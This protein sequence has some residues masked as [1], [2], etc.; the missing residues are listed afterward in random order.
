MKRTLVYVSFL[1]LLLSTACQKK[2]Q[3][4]NIVFIIAE[5]I[6][7]DLGCY[8]RTD[9]KTPVLDTMAAEGML[10]MNAFTTS[11]VCSPSRSALMTGMYQNSIGTHNHR[12]ETGPLPDPFVPITYLLRDEG[13]FTC[14]VVGEEYGTGKTDLNFSADSL[15]DGSDW[16]QRKRGQPFF[17]QIS[18]YTTHRDTHWEGIEKEVEHPVNPEKLNIPSYYPE[19]PVTRLDWAR[20]LNSIQYMDNQVGAVMERLR[21]EGLEKNTVVLFIGDHGRCHIR[22]KQWLYDAG[23]HI[24]FIMKWP[25]TVEKGSVNTD[26][27]S[28]IDIPATILDIAAA[29]IPSWMEG[30]SLIADDYSPR[31]YL[32]AARDRCDGVVDRIR[33]VRTENYKYI[34]NYM[35]ERPYTQ[36]GHY[37]AFFYPMIHL[38]PVLDKQGRL[39]DV[40]RQFLSESKPHEELYD[41]IADPEEIVNLAMGPEYENV[42][43]EMRK[44]LKDWELEVEDKGRTLETDEFMRG[45]L[46]KREAKYAP[47]WEARGI[48]AH[49][50][51]EVHLKW[52]EENLNVNRF[53]DN[54]PLEKEGARREVFKIV[55]RDTL[56]LY[57]FEPEGHKKGDKTPAIV[58]FHSGGWRKGHSTQFEMQSRYLASRGMVAIEADYRTMIRDSITPFEC[59]MDAKSAV[60]YLRKNADGLGI[61]PDRLAAGGG[62]AGGHLAA[63]CGHLDGLE[64]QDEDLNISSVPNALVLFNPVFDNGPQGY[65]YD[66]FGDRYMEISPV[67]NVRKDAPPAIVMLGDQDVNL[68]LASARFYEQEMNKAGNRC[69][70]II[71]EGQSHGFFN[72]GKGGYEMYSSTVWE[73]DRFLGELGYL[74]GEP[75]I[76]LKQEESK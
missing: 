21:E 52:W 14:N 40:Q 76:N 60:R 39:T 16:N 66:L 69:E 68:S 23:I 29:N 42:L 24:P 12:S 62:S 38:L 25:G 46:L 57:I 27:V 71:Y 9:L 15:F 61:D 8:G 22:G 41:L 48:S 2:D 45:F 53:L 36:F 32:I 72:R 10:F 43:V 63:A 4:P 74:E 55:G 6:S 5:D 54:Q 31:Q 56:Y 35:P 67:H 73:M 19:H 26:L 75:T 70:V 65:R 17:A 33:S 49:D 50:P 18:I 64:H 20:Y 3:R 44:K 30:R 59:V 7:T 13:Y 28:A 1:S 58:F 47:L 34:R 11:P 51:P 37:K